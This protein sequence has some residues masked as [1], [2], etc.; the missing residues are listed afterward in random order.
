MKRL[1]FIFCLTASWLQADGG[2]PVGQAE[3]D[4]L[5]VTLFAASIPVRA[6]ALDAGV[7]IQEIPSN[8]PV[9]EADVSLSTQ[10]A[11]RSAGPPVRMPAWCST[12][13]PGSEIPATTAHSANKLLFGAFLPVPASGRWEVAVTIRRGPARTRVVIPLDV[14]PPATPVATWWP[15]LAIVPLAVALYAWQAIFPRARRNQN[16]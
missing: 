13:S 9:T 6:G 1:L 15:L 11:S 7:L 12:L 2:R 4:G 3:A 14:A 8:L 16:F 5:R 10:N